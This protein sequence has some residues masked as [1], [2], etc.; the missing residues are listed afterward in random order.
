M[1]ADQE[2][3]EYGPGFNGLSGEAVEAL[4]DQHAERLLA[5]LGV[6]KDDASLRALQHGF[7]YLR[8]HPGYVELYTPLRGPDARAVV[9]DARAAGSALAEL[10]NRLGSRTV[11]LVRPKAEPWVAHIIAPTNDGQHMYGVKLAENAEWFWQF[12]DDLDQIAATT[13]YFA[14]GNPGG[15]SRSA[16]SAKVTIRFFVAAVMRRG[17]KVPPFNVGTTALGTKAAGTTAYQNRRRT[18]KWNEFVRACLE[19]AKIPEPDKL[20]EIVKRAR[21]A[22]GDNKKKPSN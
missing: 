22:H 4:A 8:I 11:N 15:R 7:S 9:K 6:Q 5:I 12:I 17:L 14:K 13:E 21:E 1:A 20:H 18:R 3:P 2:S 10:F 19:L 16:E